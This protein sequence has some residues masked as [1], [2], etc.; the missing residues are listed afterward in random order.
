LTTWFVSFTLRLNV[1]AVV[2]VESYVTGD[3]SLLEE[4][5]EFEGGHLGCSAAE[6]KFEN[7]LWRLP[8]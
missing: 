4:E 6:I 1:S 3:T 5:K 2:E 8:L 7:R